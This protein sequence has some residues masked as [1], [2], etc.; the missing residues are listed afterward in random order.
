MKEEDAKLKPEDRKEGGVIDQNY[1]MQ[2]VEHL[3]ALRM[4]SI[5]IVECVAAWK[6]HVLF[7]WR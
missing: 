5:N 7:P 6:E 3:H 1:M 2:F 4:F